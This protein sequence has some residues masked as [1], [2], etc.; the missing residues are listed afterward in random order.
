MEIRNHHFVRVILDLFVINSFIW[1]EEL[2]FVINF[3]QVS[4]DGYRFFFYSE[5][6]IWV[7]L[8]LQKYSTSD[9]WLN[10]K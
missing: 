8:R 5:L 6:I 1:Y 7:N 9:N 3:S 2:R 4:H 10:V